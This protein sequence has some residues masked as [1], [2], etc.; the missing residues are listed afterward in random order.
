[1]KTGEVRLR[2]DVRGV[3]GVGRGKG[4][5]KEI[6]EK[7]RVAARATSRKGR[8]RR[9]ERE[10]RWKSRAKSVLALKRQLHR[11]R[12]ADSLASGC[13]RHVTRL[14]SHRPVYR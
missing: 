7:L 6:T 3:L 5:K 11:R 8:F 1:M 10:R 4:R 12:T 9:R 2:S 13:A 14:V